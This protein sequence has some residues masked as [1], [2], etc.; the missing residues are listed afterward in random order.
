MRSGML[1]T[2]WPVRS[3]FGRLLASSPTRRQMLTLAAAG[4]LALGLAGCTDPPVAAAPPLEPDELAVNRAVAAATALRADALRLADTDPELAGLLRRIAA[5][6]EQHLAALGSPVAS[7][8]PSASPDPSATAV[9]VTAT[10]LI[11]AETAAAR[12]AL[13]DGEA[14]APAFAVLLCRI[15]AARIVDADLLSAAVG[16][17][18]P[19][20]LKPARDVAIGS[21][22]PSPAAAVAAPTSTATPDP[23]GTED[24]DPADPLATPGPLETTEPDETEPADPGNDDDSDL[25]NPTT[26]AQTALDRL[27]AGEHAAVFAYPLIVARSTG[28]RRALASQLWQVHRT[29]RDE[30]AARLEIAGVRPTVAEPAYDVGTVPANPA[31]AAALAARIERGLAALAADLV[32]AGTSRNEVRVLG[33]DQL[34]LAARRTAAWSGKP[35]AFPGLVKTAGSTPTPTA[36]P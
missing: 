24:F 33:A 30:I 20:V 15:A 7:A 27:L 17:K 4:G 1:G 32:A 5:G 28:G 21:A 36:T 11:K 8:T 10:A 35:L 14:A 23:F 12:G 34:V 9:P 26:P 18:P 19:G 22:T 25:S 6:H 31:K 29:E 16:R 3:P 2:P 13:R